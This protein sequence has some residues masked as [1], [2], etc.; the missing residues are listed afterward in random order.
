MSTRM[1]RPIQNAEKLP[2]TSPDRM[3]SEAPPWRDEVTISCTCRDL[4]LV[5][6]RVNSGMSAPASV[7]RLMITAR[8]HHRPSWP[9]RS[10]SSR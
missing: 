7:P 2:A 9:G 3:L 8:F 5:N 6:A 10:P 1:T 4:V